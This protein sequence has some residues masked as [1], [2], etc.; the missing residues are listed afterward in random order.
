MRKELSWDSGKD[1]ASPE[2]EIERAINF[3]EFDFI[4]E[5]QGKYGMDKFKKVLTT[6]KGLSKNLSTGGQVLFIPGHKNQWSL[7]R[8][9]VNRIQSLIPPRTTLPLTKGSAFLDTVYRNS[10]VPNRSL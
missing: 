1:S 9:T 8:V 2:V 4:K 7:F 5:V 10:L 3:G 6:R